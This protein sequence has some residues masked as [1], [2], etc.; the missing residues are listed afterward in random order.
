MSTSFP[1]R[2]ILSNILLTVKVSNLF[3]Q[4]IFVGSLFVPLLLVL[5]HLQNL[6]TLSRFYNHPNY[7]VNLIFLLMCHL[8]LQLHLILFYHHVKIPI[9]CLLDP[10]WAFI[11]LRLFQ[12]ALTMTKPCSVK[13]EL[14][15]DLWKAFMK[16][17][18]DALIKNNTWSLVPL[19]SDKK[20]RVHK[21]FFKI[22]KLLDNTLDKRKSRKVTI[23]L[24]GLI[25]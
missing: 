12:L 19:P 25:F 16:Q 4:F 13:K 10:K 14:S 3:I 17:E 8:Y 5:L 6:L 20:V 24:L 15:N 9:L 1:I 18:F 21:W 7:L 2:N 23:K 22:K 11:N